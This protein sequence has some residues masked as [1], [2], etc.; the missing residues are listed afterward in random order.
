MASNDSADAD[1][2][3]NFFQSF[4]SPFC[5]SNSSYPYY[6]FQS[7]TMFA[8]SISY[9]TIISSLISSKSSFIPGPDN[10]PSCLL[11]ECCSSLAAPL[12]KLFNLSLESSTFPYLWKESYIIPL[13]KKGGKSDISNYRGIAKLSAIPK[14]FEKILVSSLQHLCKSIISPTQHGFIKGRSTTTNLLE[15]TSLVND[16]FS[17]KKQTDVIYTDFSKA[18]DSVN[19]DLLLYKLRCIGFPFAFLRWVSTYL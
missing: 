5:T 8:P 19:H 9:N 16:A 17:E 4:Y 3:A 10:I 11:K 13:H 14:L 2:F 15:F 12:H 6:N 7:N 18:F 1:L